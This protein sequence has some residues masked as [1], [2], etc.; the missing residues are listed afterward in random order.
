MWLPVKLALKKRILSYM[1]RDIIMPKLKDKSKQSYCNIP[2][3]QAGS[4][5]IRLC[6]EDINAVQNGKKWED[7]E[8]SEKHQMQKQSRIQIGNGTPNRQWDVCEWTRLQKPTQH[9][10]KEKKNHKTKTQTNLNYIDQTSLGKYELQ[11]DYQEKLFRFK[12][13]KCHSLQL[14]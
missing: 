10:G 13:P 12:T 6:V 2:R 14:N 8:S 9:C 4:E 5:R 11:V 7:L 3:K 1:T